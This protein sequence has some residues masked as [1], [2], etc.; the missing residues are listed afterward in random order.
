MDF[1]LGDRLEID[2][3]IPKFG[4]SDN[5]SNMIKGINM[6]MVELYTCANHTQQLAIQ[7][8]FKRVKDDDDLDTMDEIAEKCR[9]LANHVK[10]A[11]NSR[12]L[13]HEECKLSKHYPKAIPVGNDSR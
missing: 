3:A 4:T 2:H 13:L 12:K 10:R 5:A 8:A 1:D 7:D 6:S 9:L 11:D